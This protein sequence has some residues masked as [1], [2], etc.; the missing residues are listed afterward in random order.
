METSEKRGALLIM[1]G[2]LA[3]GKTTIADMLS[4]RIKDVS[5]ISSDLLRGQGKAGRIWEVMPVMAE[6]FLREGLVVMIDATNYTSAHRERFVSVARDVKCHHL[7]IHITAGLD[8]LLDRNLSRRDRIPPKALFRLSALF[9]KPGNG[10]TLLI[11]TD[12]TAPEE[13]VELL[14]QGIIDMACND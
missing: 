1:T 2:L 8:T 11:D 5:I 12:T 9:E 6:N 14:Q 10:N 3:S 7:I 4:M 13:A